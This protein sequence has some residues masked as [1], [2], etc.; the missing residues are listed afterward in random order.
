MGKQPL[1]SKPSYI[2]IPFHLS[3]FYR[4]LCMSALENCADVSHYRNGHSALTGLGNSSVSNPREMFSLYS[5]F[6]L[7]ML[8]GGIAGKTTDT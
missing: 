2:K 7:L 6:S 3:T 5:S 4:Y 8:S 1:R